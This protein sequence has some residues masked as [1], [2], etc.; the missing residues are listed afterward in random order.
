MYQQLISREILFFAH[1]LEVL[2]K[3]RV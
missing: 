3:E 1:R 2:V